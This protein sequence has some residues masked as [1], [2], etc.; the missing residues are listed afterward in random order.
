MH[1]V[2]TCH[3]LRKLLAAFPLLRM[4]C[5]DACELHDLSSVRAATFFEIFLYLPDGGSWYNWRELSNHF[6]FT[7]INSKAR[8]HSQGG[9]KGGDLPA[10]DE[11]RN[12]GQSCSRR[13]AFSAVL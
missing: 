6:L 11:M 4:L 5:L 13:N 1:W 9:C 7:G 10:A 8:P 2:H 3:A 12:S